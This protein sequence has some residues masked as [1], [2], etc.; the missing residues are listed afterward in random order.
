VRATFERRKTAFPVQ[1]PVGLTNEF[2]V[3]KQAAW[4]AFLR[5]S[6]LTAPPLAEVIGRLEMHTYQ[7]SRLS[8]EIGFFF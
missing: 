1:D 7:S 4:N 3:E 2:A 8:N 5:R 6:G